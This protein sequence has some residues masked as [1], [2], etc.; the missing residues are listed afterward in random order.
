MKFASARTVSLIKG[1]TLGQRKE[2]ASFGGVF[3]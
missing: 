3:K 1:F 2:A